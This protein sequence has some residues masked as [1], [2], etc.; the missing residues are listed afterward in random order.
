LT[1]IIAKIPVSTPLMAV[2][3]PIELSK[4]FQ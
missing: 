3:A 1:K 4:G 2:D